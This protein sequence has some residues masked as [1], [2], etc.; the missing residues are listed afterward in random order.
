LGSISFPKRE[1]YDPEGKRSN[2]RFQTDEGD[3]CGGSQR[4]RHILHGAATGGWASDKLK[5]ESGE[6]KILSAS[7][8]DKLV[9]QPLIGFLFAGE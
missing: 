4:A 8:F 1:F 9:R 7:Q 5:Q 3:S 6:T 2:N